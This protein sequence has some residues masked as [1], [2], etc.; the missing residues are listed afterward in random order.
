MYKQIL[1]DDA[2]RFICLKYK[3]DLQSKNKEF[4]FKR[5]RI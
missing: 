1:Q 5:K 4:S 3:T 2:L